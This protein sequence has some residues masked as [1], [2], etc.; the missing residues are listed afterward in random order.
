MLKYQV[1]NRVHELGIVPV[2]RGNS[3]D[4]ALG[5][6]KALIDGGIDILEV[7]FTIPNALDVFKELKDQLPDTATLGAGTVMD[8]TTARLA[9]LNGAKFIV[10]P[11]FSEEVAKMCNLY[12]VPYMPGCM[13]FTEMTKALEYGVDLIKLFPGSLPG[14]SYVKAIHGPLPQANIM[15]TGGVSLDNIADWFAA[16]VFA[17]GAGSNLVKGSHDEIVEQAKKYLAKI[18]ECRE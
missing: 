15:P 2:I 4:E 16:G 18:A 5:Y 17:V 3:K 7:T 1:L 9:I 12:Q 6:C 13:T 10:S 14:P 11:G 8:A